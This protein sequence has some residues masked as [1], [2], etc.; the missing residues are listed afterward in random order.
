MR[1]PQRVG[2]D[3]GEADR[4]DCARFDE[5]AEFADRVLD[6]NRL[7]DP[8]H[9][10]EID[11]VDAEPLHRPFQGLADVGR[12]CCRRTRAPSSRRRIANLV[13]SVTLPRRLGSSARNL[14][15]SLLAKPV[16]VDVGGVPEI[17]AEV[18]RPRQRPH[19]LRL[20]RSARRSRRSSWRRSRRPRPSHFAKRAAASPTTFAG[21]GKPGDPL[22]DAAARRQVR[23]A[24]PASIRRAASSRSNR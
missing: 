2:R 21:Q 5:P 13:A 14:P 10:V 23:P 17:D 12:R 18:E 20:R 4:A 1:A 15:I 3:F 16:A 24:Q 11:V 7:V 9:I 19:R 6:R 8:M 22:R